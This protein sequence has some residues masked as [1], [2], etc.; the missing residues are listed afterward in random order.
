MIHRKTIKRQIIY[1]FA[2]TLIITV[3]LQLILFSAL[4]MRNNS[5]VSSVFESVTKNTVEQIERLNSD[6]ADLSYRLSTHPNIQNSLY[7]YNHFENVQYLSENQTILNDYR[8]RNKNIVYLGIINQGELWLS[9]E[10]ESVYDDVR[11]I[12]K[13]LD[14]NHK[15]SKPIYPFSVLKDGKIFFSC[16]T[17]IFPIDVNYYS[18]ANRDN[19]VVCIYEMLN[20][21]YFSYE[22]IDNSIISLQITDENDRIMLSSDI[23]KHGEK[24][25]EE[26]VSS[27]VFS[28]TLPI[29]S[30]N[31][32]VTISSPTNETESFF[33]SSLLFILFM[34]CIN[35]IFFIIMYKLLKG[36]IIHRISIITDEVKKIPHGGLEY[37]VF[38]PY[39]DEF[40]E[41]ADITNHSLEKIH[42]LNEEKYNALENAYRAE[43]LQKETQLIYLSGQVSPHF[44][45]NSMAHIQGL[46]LQN[47]SK[48]ISEMVIDLSQ[49]FRYFSNNRPFSTI[50]QDIDCTVKYFNTINARRY[51]PLDIK[52]EIS[53]DVCDIPCLKMTYQPIIENVLKHAYRYNENGLVTIRS[54]FDE[55]DAIIEI[56]DTGRGFSETVLNELKKKLKSNMSDIPV[57]DHTGLLN[58]DMRLKLFYGNSAGIQITSPP[59]KP[60]A[61]RITFSKKMHSKENVLPDFTF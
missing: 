61:I 36:I 42:E 53:D 16:V 57:S 14:G 10:T 47:R 2:I 55:N 39:D 59:N 30:T 41:I 7:K 1:Y 60:A 24:A 54:I 18:S 25:S 33:D 37:K 44:L 43:L 4:R 46:A 8:A 21:N 17:P 12:I 19:Y 48:E 56:S 49:V 11:R 50:K 32:K 26:K 58:V 6:V 31:W 45:Y 23:T 34:I 13:S 15:N 52:C 51:T 28:K 29:P 22:F 38:Y 20:I 40:S 3:I 5:L 9:S 35:A 27:G